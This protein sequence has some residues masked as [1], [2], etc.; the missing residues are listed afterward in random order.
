MEWEKKNMIAFETP[1][2][3]VQLKN[4]LPDQEVF[5]GIIRIY[6]KYI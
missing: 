1:L 4:S 6:L 3:C 5:Q 2:F